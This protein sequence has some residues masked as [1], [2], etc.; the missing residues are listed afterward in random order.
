MA[1]QT[2]NTINNTTSTSNINTTAV[3]DAFHPYYLQSSDDPRIALVTQPLIALNYQQ[4]SRAV[5]LTLSVKNKLGLIDGS[6]DKP[7][8]KDL[9]TLNQGTLSITAYFTK[10]R[11]L[12]D[13]LDALTPLLT[14]VCVQNFCTFEVNTKLETYEQLNSLSLFLMGLNEAFTGVRRQML[15][16]NP[17]PT[18][19][20]D[21]SLLLQEESQR[22]A[23][24]STVSD[25]MATNAKFSG[26][27]SR[28]FSEKV[29]D[30]CHNTGYSQ[31]KYFFLH[32]YPDWHRL[33]GKPKPKLRS[34][35]A[36]VKKAAQITVKASNSADKSSDYGS[37]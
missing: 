11:T 21:Y 15:M 18:L 7:L 1:N 30:Y 24:L 6:L 10:M 8:K 28:P 31:D 14:C 4:W 17:L 35:C 13:E 12:T 26:Q 36:P 20:Q 2:N 34:P 23:H 32:G 25:N 19:S 37:T 27:K 33:Y 5:K 16:M 3:I 29:Y 9:V 22:V